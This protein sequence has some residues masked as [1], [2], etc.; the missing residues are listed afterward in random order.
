LHSQ[1][2]EL[3]N[4]HTHLLAQFSELINPHTC[5]LGKVLC[6]QFID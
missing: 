3:M 2:T 4:P 5:L 6:K 1:F